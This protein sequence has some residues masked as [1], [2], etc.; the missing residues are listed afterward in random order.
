M[1]Q[2]ATA[3]EIIKIAAGEI[4][5]TCSYLHKHSHLS[6][7]LENFWYGFKFGLKFYFPLHFI[8]LLFRYKQLLQK[9]LSTLRTA[10]KGCVRS[11]LVLAVMV[12][13]GKMCECIYLKGIGKLNQACLTF[14]AAMCPLAAFIETPARIS[15]MAIFVMPR[16]FEAFWKFLNRRGMVINVPF[17]QVIMFSAAMAAIMYSHYREPENIKPMYRKAC[18]KFFGEN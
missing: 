18:E 14:A 10:L 12:L 5:C 16:F 4:L 11:T 15:D 3:D 2:N 17:G 6:H 13:I 7:W 8:P 1:S 9:P